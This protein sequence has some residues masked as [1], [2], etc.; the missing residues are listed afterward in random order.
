VFRDV[1]ARHKNLKI[2]LKSREEKVTKPARQQS[3]AW[4]LFQGSEG[5]EASAGK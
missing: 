2:M 1:A 3:T 4:D 5:D